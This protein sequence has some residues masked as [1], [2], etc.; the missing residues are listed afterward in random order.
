[1]RTTIWAAMLFTIGVSVSTA[2]ELTGPVPGSSVP[3]R[4]DPSAHRFAL[5]LQYEPS[6]DSTERQFIVDQAGMVF[7]EDSMGNVLSE[8][9]LDVRDRIVDL[10]FFGTK[11]PFGDYDERGL[12]GFTFHPDFA[13]EG[14][15]GFAKVYGY[16][17]AP[18]STDADF[19][20]PLA[21]DEE[22]DSQTVLAEWTVESANGNRTDSSSYREIFRIDQ[23]QFNHNGGMLGFGPDDGFLYIGLG[24]GGASNDVGAGHSAI[25]NSQDTTNI[26]GSILRIDVDGNNSANGKYGIP[27]D[28]P[29][30]NDPEKL[31]EIYAYGV[32]NAWRFSWDNGRMILADVGQNNI[33]EVDLVVA[34]GNYGWNLKEGTFAFNPEDATVST[35]TAG[36]AES[37][38]DPVLEYDHPEGRSIIG[39]FVYR[40][41]R[42]PEL[43]GKY[44]FADWSRDFFTPQGRL[45]VGDLETGEIE[46]LADLDLFVYGIGRDTDNELYMMAGKNLGPFG[47]EGQIYAIV[48]EPSVSIWFG[49]IPF[50]VLQLLGRET[51]VKK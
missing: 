11:D 20:V 27:T 14:E 24:D 36:L 31:D 37:L 40:G 7:V 16:F 4:L 26:H 30:V 48:P 21:N 25:G 6:P 13:K 15:V 34:G 32:R 33:E 1:M 43:V 18:V 19:T 38:I 47:S 49:V 44:V 51:R 10:G 3:I 45:L 41:S 28:N 35:D 29:F 8:P 12:L 22:F 2:G 50:V 5:P 39:G 46:S 9:F 17:S 23:P 42:M